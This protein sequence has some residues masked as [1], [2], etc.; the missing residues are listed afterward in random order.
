MTE[1]LFI[2]GYF[3]SWEGL[4]QTVILAVGFIV[5]IWTLRKDTEARRLQLLHEMNK[6]GS[7]LSLKLAELSF[8]AEHN[9]ELV[10]EKHGILI[11]EHLNF[12]EHL[13]LLINEKK[14]D[15][16][17]AKRYWGKNIQGLFQQSEYK[18]RICP[19]YVEII[20]LHQ[21]WFQ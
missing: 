18:D 19:T 11:K 1:C 9:N 6:H 10:S 14:I 8:M 20:K 3:C 17:L 15:E 7:D 16:K 13:S 2:W 5:T 4:A 21:K 12:Y